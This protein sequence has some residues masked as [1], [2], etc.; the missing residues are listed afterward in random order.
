MALPE[1]H[2]GASWQSLA[3]EAYTQS[4]ISFN[5]TLISQSYFSNVTFNIT[6]NVATQALAANTWTK[7]TYTASTN[8]IILNNNNILTGQ[9]LFSVGT[10]RITKLANTPFFNNYYSAT[11]SAVISSSSFLTHN[12]SL[13]IVKNG[14]LS[15]V[16]PYGFPIR[17]DQN[18]VAFGYKVDTSFFQLNPTD[19]IELYALAT[20][21]TTITTSTMIMNL[22]TLG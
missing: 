2:D 20:V 13:Q 4:R 11:G 22:N 14:V 3:T 8:S 18:G 5:N 7:L 12:I 19:Y 17:V 10:N 6:G 9:N 16:L 15:S 1:F 21:G